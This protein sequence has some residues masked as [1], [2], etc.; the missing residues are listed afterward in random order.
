MT[1]EITIHCKWESTHVVEVP[2]DFVVPDNLTDFPA[3]V[4]EEL[5]SENASLV[6][7]E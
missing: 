1:K 5:T 4:L 3:D 6:D 7:W 2:D